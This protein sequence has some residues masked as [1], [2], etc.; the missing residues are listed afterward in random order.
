MDL[1][2]S[3]RFALTG[4]AQPCTKAGQRSK[5]NF[6]YASSVYYS[7]FIHSWHYLTQELNESDDGGLRC[8][9]A[10]L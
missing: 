1:S 9:E 4:V 6:N 3:L 5:R 10:F 8:G 2:G 7:E